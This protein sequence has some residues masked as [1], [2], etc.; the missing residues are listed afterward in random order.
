[1]AC[2]LNPY[3]VHLANGTFECII[4][5]AVDLFHF[6]SQWL[7]S[8]GAGLVLHNLAVYA[9]SGFLSVTDMIAFAVYWDV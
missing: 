7:Q 5:S 3:S 1:M 4:S 2:S 8:Q 6:Q 9:V